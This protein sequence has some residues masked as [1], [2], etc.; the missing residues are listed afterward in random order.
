MASAGFGPAVGSRD[1]TDESAFSTLPDP[2][3]WTT[4]NHRGEDGRERTGEE[5]TR[6][7]ERERERERKREE[8]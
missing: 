3:S 1:V 6:E 7:R 2:N 5:K 4:T 8:R